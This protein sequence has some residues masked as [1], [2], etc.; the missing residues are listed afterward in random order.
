MDV[1]REEDRFQIQREDGSWIMYSLYQVRHCF[2]TLAFMNMHMPMLRN[3]CGILV[4]IYKPDAFYYNILM[5]ILST[6]HPI[7]TPSQHTP[8]THPLNPSQYTP[9]TR[10]LNTLSHPPTPLPVVSESRNGTYSR[11][12]QA[13]RGWRRGPKEI[14]RGRQPV[15]TA[16]IGQRNLLA[17][18][19]TV[20]LCL[21][22]LSRMVLV[23]CNVCLYIMSFD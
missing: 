10:P 21:V 23:L 19:S 18:Y 4:F 22:L 14:I 1:R 12:D 15:E 16:Q 20:H 2:D 8:S 7:H 5:F 17:R 11:C 13:Y 3:G 9:S 6:T